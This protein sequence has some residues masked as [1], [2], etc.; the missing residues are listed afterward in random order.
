MH[1]LH[2]LDHLPASRVPRSACSYTIHIGGTHA[3][4]LLLNAISPLVAV[5]KEEDVLRR[6][7]KLEKN[8]DS[9]ATA[10]GETEEKESNSPSRHRDEYQVELDVNRSFVHLPIGKSAEQ[11]ALPPNSHTE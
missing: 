11:D 4:P 10:E 7:K 1:H 5:I 2:Y 6:R 3:R 9:N 8:S